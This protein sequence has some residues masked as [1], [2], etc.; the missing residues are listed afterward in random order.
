MARVIFMGTPLFAVPTLRALVEHHQVV[1]VVTQ[2]DGRAGRGRKVVVSPVKQVAME[3]ELALLQPWTL[4][5][6]KVIARLAEWQPEVIVVAAFGQLLPVSVL[7]LPPH[8]SINVHAS[9]LPRYRGAAPIAAAILDGEPVTGITIMRM[10]EG[11]DTGPI[12]TRAEHPI[13][14]DETTA[15]LTAKLAGLGAQLLIETLDGWLDGA[16]E[17]QP[18]DDRAATY[19]DRLEKI[20]G[21]LDWSQPAA[22]LDRQVRA[23]DPWPGAYTTWQG[24]RLKVLHA[25][26]HP[27]WEG[28]G[29]PGQVTEMGGGIGVVT[30]QGVL[31]LIE[32]QLAG[33]KPMPAGLFARGQRDLV[34]GFLGT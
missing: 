6:A 26:P 30:G 13:A 8:G 14:P 20:D 22:Y 12:L 10:D 9:L 32:V 17:P 18:Q 2:P 21:L 23:C 11:L 1:G 34:G 16:I 33:K 28:E 25:G 7:D 29:Q 27:S 19:C 3:R 4:N 24:R 5:D 15:S 31:E